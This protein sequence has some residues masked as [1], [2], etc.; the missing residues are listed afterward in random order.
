MVSN[1]GKSLSLPIS[2]DTSRVMLAPSLDPRVV[3][4]N[5]QKPGDLN[6]FH[7]V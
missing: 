6:A 4:V 2:I 7:V 3:E 5:N 1:I